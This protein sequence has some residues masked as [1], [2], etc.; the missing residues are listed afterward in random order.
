[1]YHI[2]SCG[3]SLFQSTPPRGRRPELGSVDINLLRVSIHASAREATLCEVR[4]LRKRLFQSTP[5]R[6]RRPMRSNRYRRFI[7]VSIHAS[8]REATRETRFIPQ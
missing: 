1:M 3:M 2:A 6:G 4:R 8:A 5:P 7:E